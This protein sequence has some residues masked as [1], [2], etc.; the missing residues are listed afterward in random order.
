MIVESA[1][2]HLESWT[3]TLSDAPHDVLQVF[4]AV[5]HREVVQRVRKRRLDPE[6]GPHRRRQQ[7][8]AS[9]LHSFDG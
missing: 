1:N 3:S 7:R 9:V 5:D 6:R 4:F 2:R 8:L